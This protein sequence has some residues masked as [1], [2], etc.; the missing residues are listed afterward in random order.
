[1]AMI[2][3][4]R[5]TPPGPG[6]L[7]EG[8][9]A[10]AMAAVRE[11][12]AIGQ[13]VHGVFAM[14][15][16]FLMPLATFPK[17]LAFIFLAGYAIIRLPNTWRCYTALLRDRLL[18]ALLAWGA[19]LGISMAWSVDAGEGF[20]EFKTFRV[21]LAPWALWPVIDWTPR[22]IAALLAGVFGQTVLQGFQFLHWFG[23]APEANDDRLRGIIHPIQTGALAL[24]AVSWYMAALLRGAPLRIG[25]RIV[26]IVGCATALAGLVFAGSRGPWIA[27][28]VALPVT[29]A[30]IA[31]RRPQSR[32]RVIVTCVVLLVGGAAAWPVAHG[33]VGRRVE[34]ARSEWRAATVEGHY[35]SSVGLRVVMWRW[36]WQFFEAKPVIGIGAGSYRSIARETPE[37]QKLERFSVKGHPHSTT[38]HALSATGL[39]GGALLA[40]VLWLALVRCARE[41]DDHL[42]ACAAFGVLVGWI[43]GAQFDS[44]HLNGH[45]MGLF[46]FLVAISLPARAAAMKPRS[47]EP[48]A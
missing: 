45:L 17:D 44:Y 9:V 22:L 48:T 12:D 21:A 42:F 24:A 41:A 43:V 46:T 37:A 23:M 29:L 13:K 8:G 34:H 31:I 16:L 33:F 32:R 40:V 28:A 30:T 4:E 38:L 3:T 20:K 36:A 47:P 18:W 10:A 6:L 7:L 35:D 27:A 2:A 5:T 39:V 1:M 15:Y 11:R 14:I 25:V 19:W 26:L